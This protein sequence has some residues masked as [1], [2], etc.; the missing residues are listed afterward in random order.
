MCKGFVVEM[1]ENVAVSRRWLR[2]AVVGLCMLALALLIIAKLEPSAVTDL[3][4][5]FQAVDGDTLSSNGD[6]L[7]LLGVDAPELGQQCSGRRG[8]YDCGNTARDGLV[9]MLD[10]ADWMCEGGG[11][12]KYRRLLVR[13][14]SG[15][16]DLAEELVRQG[17]VVAE[18]SYLAAE[19]E[20][21][22]GQ[23]GIWDGTFERPSDWRRARQLL[24]MEPEEGFMTFAIERI[25]AWWRR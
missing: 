14:M 1:G 3:A 15:Q 24:E 6:R 4:G 20:A 17:L 16:T 5:P 13:C 12:D 21:R 10:R 25:A 8:S 18:G 9:A 2:D 19:A 7:R 11:Q 23:L 22:T